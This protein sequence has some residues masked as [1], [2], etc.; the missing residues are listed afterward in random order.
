MPLWQS[1]F[2]PLL[3]SLTYPHLSLLIHRSQKA[4]GSKPALKSSGPTLDKQVPLEDVKPQSSEGAFQA[5]EKIEFVLLSSSPP[6]L[7]YPLP[8]HRLLSRVQQLETQ[9]SE[10]EWKDKALENVKA[11]CV[12]SFSLVFLPSS[13]R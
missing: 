9:L 13:S 5:E 11:E 4:E 3:L 2:V 1:R 6:Y 12:T 10:I 8:L 7:T